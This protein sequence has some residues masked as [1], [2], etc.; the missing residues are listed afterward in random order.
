MKYEKIINEMSLEEKASL[1][2]GKN[3]WETQEIERL[4]IPSI[5]LSDG[6]H[7]MRKQAAAADHLGLNVSIPATCFPTA[8]TM[9]NTWNEE[10]GETLGKY[11]GQEAISQHV[12]VVLGPGTNMKRNPLCGRNFEY[13]SED[14]YLAGKMAASYIRGIQS[15]GISACVKHFACN[16]QEE[17]RMTL[18]SVL[19]E[20]TLREIYL[21]AFEIAIK[22]GKTKCLMSSYNLVNGVYANENEHLLKDILRNEWG[23]KGVVVTDW[24]GDN[25]RVLALKAGNELEMPSA[26]GD[27]AEDIINAIK[28][29][30]LDEK[31]LD[32][33][34]DRLLTLI[35]DTNKVFEGES[36]TFN[37]EKHHQ[38]AKM[39]AEESIVLLKNN[40][41]LPISTNKKVALIGDF[42]YEPR[43]QG[44]G[45]SVVNPTKLDKT[46]DLIDKSG[47]QIIGH[48]KGFNRYGKKKKGLLKK[49]LKLASSADVVV[50]Y[51]GLDEVT[52]AEGLDRKDMK[53]AANQIE[54]VKEIKKL[55]KEVVVVLSCGSAVELD[56]VDDVD[57][58]LHAY[59]S[60]QAGA[61]AILNILSGKV[62]PSGKLSETYPYKLEDVA[63][64]DNFPSHKRT[65]EYREGLFIG[66]R[67]FD[68]A[69]VKVR[70][71]FGYG[72][73]YTKFEYSNLKVSEKGV[74]FDIENVG[75][76]EGKEV[77]QL[78]VAKS[79]SKL[80]RAR[81]ELKGFKKVG[82]KPHEKKT[83]TIEF[84]D[85]TF[86]YFNTVTNKWEIED[87][88]YQILI[89]ASSLDI[90]LEGSVHKTG[91]TDKY[92]LGVKDLPTYASG[93]VRNVSDEE[94]EKLLGREIPNAEIP[95][96][97]KRKTRMIVDYNT[98]VQELRY[99]KGWSGR[100]FAW[101]IRFAVKFLKAFGNK[102]MAN[103]LVM[104]VVHQPMRG[105]SRMTGGMIHWRQLDGLIMMFNG[106]FFKGAHK[107][108]KEGRNYKKQR[109]LK[110]KQLKESKKND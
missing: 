57:G 18:D 75:E 51:L 35:F 3:F 80:I 30:T 92:P 5:F 70:Y 100:F 38:F 77:S 48:E 86:R 4:N 68:T 81:K 96:I 110:E 55:G 102:T 76:V 67:Y 1:M 79:D 15:N 47:L 21:T 12:N 45:S 103:T 14:P 6:P 95:F 109:K 63:S 53:L 78:Y 31:V 104:G 2:S 25:D 37:E 73:S 105:M 84:D 58:L 69:D 98:T 9:A 40:G 41:V 89:G 87:G 82:L 65:I 34:V 50:C 64:N 83:V 59:L 99:A 62:N 42:V 60:G 72:L 85:K 19:D 88:D 16:N 93:K 32:E 36:H 101:C 108:F 22:E 29:G 91:T 43:Y 33:N 61:E 7:G 26:S 54:L 28:N 46:I 52:E 23:Y 56:F 90:R 11:L 49:A 24:G 27:T 97:N 20:R 106:K 66:Y 74:T 44:A 10:L 94:F 17:N 107:F 39:A 8:A 71:P 13:F